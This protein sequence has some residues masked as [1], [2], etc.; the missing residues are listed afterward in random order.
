MCMGD[1][2]IVLLGI[3]SFHPVAGGELQPFLF[4]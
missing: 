3:I 2:L 1:N 4:P